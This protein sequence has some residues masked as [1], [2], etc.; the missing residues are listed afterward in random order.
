MEHV[1]LVIHLILTIVLIGLVLVQR[2]EGGGLG[3]G[4]SGGGLGGF[5]SAQS[6]ANALTKITTIVAFCFFSTSLILA[7]IAARGGSAPSSILDAVDNPPAATSTLSPETEKTGI[8]SESAPATSPA[9]TKPA[10][11]D[12]D[13]APAV[14]IAE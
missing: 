5:A 12:A 3:I 9:D 8:E 14:P 2:S 1:V 11:P 13:K 4:G 6:T 7:I 10:S